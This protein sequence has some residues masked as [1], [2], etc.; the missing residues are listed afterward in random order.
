MARRLWELSADQPDTARVFTSPEGL[1][2]S[3]GNLRRRVLVPATDAAPLGWVTF[4]TFRHT[5][6]KSLQ[7]CPN[8]GFLF[9]D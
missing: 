5:C 7:P 2:I 6:G 8:Q 4:H 1:P 3:Y 9:L